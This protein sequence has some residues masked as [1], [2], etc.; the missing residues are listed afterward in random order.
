MA[1]VNT[2]RPRMA[3]RDMAKALGHSPGQQDAYSKQLDGWT[4]L[5]AQ[6]EDASGGTAASNIPFP[7]TCWSWPHRSRTT[8][9][10]WAS[11]PAEW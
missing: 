8:R 11:T 5:A 2:F 9:G 10:I 1:N 7:S 3:V 4:P 6:I